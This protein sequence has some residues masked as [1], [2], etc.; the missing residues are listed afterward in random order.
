MSRGAI[1]LRVSIK[2]SASALEDSSTVPCLKK[3][4]AHQTYVNLSVWDNHLRDNEG[5][6]ESHNDKEE[7]RSRP[8]DG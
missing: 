8:A 6:D 5:D 4:R 3:T 1:P 2:L 7:R